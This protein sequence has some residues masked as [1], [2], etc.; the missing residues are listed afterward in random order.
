MNKYLLVFV[1]VFTSCD[2]D[3]NVK[4]DHISLS[5][6]FYLEDESNDL[7]TSDYIINTQNI[8]SVSGS[9]GLILNLSTNK[10]LLNIRITKPI[11]HLYNIKI[12]TD[13]ILSLIHI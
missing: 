4:N 2:K 8:D 11:S 13:G 6:P 10:S 1:I 12:W 9:T 7:V 5:S 3:I